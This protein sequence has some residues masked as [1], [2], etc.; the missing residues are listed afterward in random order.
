M[1]LLGGWFGL[2]TAAGEADL[3]QQA[4]QLY[5]E[6]EYRQAADAYE[7][8]LQEQGVAPELYYNLGNAYFKA[9]EVALSILNYE[10]A[11]RLNPRFDDARYNLQLAQERVIDNIPPAQVFFVKR[12]RIVNAVEKVLY[13]VTDDAKLFCLGI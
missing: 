12:G 5:S 3:L 13:I 8:L 4:N 7:Q 2:A 6:G 9:G 10:R 11:L 1:L